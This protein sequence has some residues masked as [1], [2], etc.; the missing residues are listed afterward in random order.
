M[1]SIRI[2]NFRSL[3]DTGNID[4]K[5]ITILVGKNSAGKSTFLRTFPLFKQSVEARTKAPIL[6]YSRSGVDFG[7]YKDVKPIFA[8]SQDFLEFEFILQDIKLNSHRH[9]SYA[10]YD[11][12]SDL[13]ICMKIDSDS[14]D[15]PILKT[16]ELNIF[17]NQIEIL[18]DTKEQTI[19]K[20]IIN[21]ELINFEHKLSY[22]SRG[23][24]ID[25]IMLKD[26][27]NRDDLQGYTEKKLLKLIS[28][29]VRKGTSEDNLNMILRR[30]STLCDKEDFLAQL[31]AIKKPTTWSKKMEEI[32]IDSTYFK[33]FYQSLIL[34]HLED[35]LQTANN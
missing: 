29:K 13:K 32:N 24:L 34:L 35:I 3:K 1:K 15:S 33:D 5:P 19:N 17:K 16:I 6:L 31:R 20:L 8:T 18:F 22:F 7:S 11:L 27:T 4:L 10:R 23:L 9:F 25:R 26:D 28:K 14:N 12:V 2:R 21:N 30:V